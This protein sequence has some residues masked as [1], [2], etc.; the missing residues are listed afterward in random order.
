MVGKNIAKN[1]ELFNNDKT[2][3]YVDI[4]TVTKYHLKIDEIFFILITRLCDCIFE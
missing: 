2:N 1:Y 4:R 3:W